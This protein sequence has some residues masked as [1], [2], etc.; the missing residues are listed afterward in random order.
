MISEYAG[1]GTAGLASSEDASQPY[2]TNIKDANR[3]I[4]IRLPFRKLL[5]TSNSYNDASAS[6]DR[7]KSWTD[8]NDN[9]IPAEDKIY[10]CVFNNAP[11]LIVT[12]PENQRLYW[13]QNVLFHGTT[14]SADRSGHT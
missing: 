11:G 14:S 6:L 10:C 8:L 12:P 5:K 9:D 7:E 13:T 2:V 3:N 4:R 1:E